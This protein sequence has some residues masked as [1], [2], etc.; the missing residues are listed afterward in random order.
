MGSVAALA[1]V[2]LPPVI[3]NNP[4]SSLP[5]EQIEKC[6]NGCQPPQ[7]KKTYLSEEQIIQHLREEDAKTDYFGQLYKKIIPFLKLNEL[8]YK[9]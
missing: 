2:P 7:I 6:L 9:D 1:E 8:E 3:K 4:N 5:E